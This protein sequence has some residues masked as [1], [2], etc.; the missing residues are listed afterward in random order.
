MQLANVYTV[1]VDVMAAAT[2]LYVSFNDLK[3]F[4]VRNDVIIL[5][6]ILYA[7]HA[8]LLNSWMGVL[9]DL[10]FA[11]LMFAIMLVFYAYNLMGGGDVK[12]LTVALLWAGHLF[13]LPFAIFL[14][15][16]IV[17][18][19]AAVQIGWAGGR[20]PDDRRR[21]PFAPAIAGALIGTIV[22]GHLQPW[23][24][25]GGPPSLPRSA[26]ELLRNLQSGAGGH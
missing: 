26:S 24:S 10:G 25:R 3:N 20:L 17:I 9:I 16:F 23:T 1:L 19:I 8:I 5:L 14:L 18:H 11:T 6:F 7:I 12:L 22:L 21:I 4:K 15:I 2:L 13:A